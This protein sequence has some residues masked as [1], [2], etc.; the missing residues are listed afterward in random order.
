M[1]LDER[2]EK[3]ARAL[4]AHDHSGSGDDDPRGDPDALWNKSGVKKNWEIYKTMAHMALLWAFPELFADPPQG[5]IAPWEATQEMAEARAQ[6][7][8]QRSTVQIW[9]DMRDSHLKA[10]A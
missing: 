1:T 3:A 4:F 10:K 2:I 5:W 9:N 7:V 6:E 8:R